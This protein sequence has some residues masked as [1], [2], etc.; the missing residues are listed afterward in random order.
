MKLMTKKQIIGIAAA[1]IFVFS[2]AA[3]AQKAANLDQLIQ[4]VK[5]SQIAE[6]EEH[7]A[8]EA[9]F[10]KSKANQATLLKN[11]RSTKASEERR[12]ERLEQQFEKQDLFVK[13]KRKQYEERLGSLKELFGHL[14]SA[15]GDLRANIDTSIVSAQLPGRSVFLEAFIDKMNSDTKLPT[16]EEIERMWEELLRETVEAGKIVKFTANVSDPAGNTAERE[17]VR[18]GNYNLVSDGKYLSFNHKNGTISELPRQPGEHLSGAANLQDATTGFVRV[19]ID[20]TGPLGGGLLRALIGSPSL[21]ERWHQGG[22]VGYVISSIFA[23][24]LLVSIWRFLVLSSV[25]GRVRSQLK[26]KS[27]NTN[28]PLGRV[29]KVAEDNP[30]IDGESLELKLE[31]AILKERPPIE[32]YLGMIKIISMVAPLLG[33]LG[34]VV[35]M[36]QTFQAITIYGAGDPQAMAGGI[37][38]ALVTTVLGLVVAIPTVLIHAFLY[39]KA[40]GVIHILE[41]QSAGMIAEKVESK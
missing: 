40:K 36:I 2:S 20:P 10:R 16:I 13:Q 11:A 37:S 7:K 33:L 24:A 15:T 21:E 12:S 19:G 5:N 6:S 34:T 31:E 14:T 9:E 35:G 25:G 17:V 32:A 26:A 39:G 27:A 18:I 22:F 1:S 3:F 29:L 38:G 28:N 41:E 23:V 8:R 4:M 30:G